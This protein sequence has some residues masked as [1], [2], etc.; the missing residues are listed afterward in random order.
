LGDAQKIGSGFLF[1]SMVSDTNDITHVDVELLD[2]KN[3]VI[4]QGESQL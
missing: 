2:G 4:A 3:I 1:G